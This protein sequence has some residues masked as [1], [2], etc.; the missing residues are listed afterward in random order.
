MA[1]FYL[2]ND[3][4]LGLAPLLLEQ[5]HDVTSTRDLRLF[6]AGDVDQLLTAVRN[7]WVLLTSGLQ[8]A[9]SLVIPLQVVQR[10]FKCASVR[11]QSA[12]V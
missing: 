4:S 1:A 8:S 6:R 2:D 12:Y 3:V 5:G 7:G 11:R 10:V 9:Q